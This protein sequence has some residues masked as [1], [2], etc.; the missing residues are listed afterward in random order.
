MT[1]LFYLI[2]KRMESANAGNVQLG[3]KPSLHVRKE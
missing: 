2:R 1:I 3:I